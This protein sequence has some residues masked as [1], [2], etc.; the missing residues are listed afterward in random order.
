MIEKIL[1]EYLAQNLSVR[2]GL[3]E[4][5]KEASFVVLEKVGSKEEGYLK[6]ATFAIQSYGATLWES[7]KLNEEL[8]RVMEGL[9]GLN[10]ICHVSLQTDYN[11]TDT[12]KKRYRYQAVYYITHY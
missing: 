5:E 3:E 1:L 6:N 12:Q 4:I 10:E 8:K 7:A 11:Y 9:V 2:V